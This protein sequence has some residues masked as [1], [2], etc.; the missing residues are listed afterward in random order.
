MRSY[1]LKA[2]GDEH[3]L[4]QVGCNIPS[5]KQAFERRHNGCQAVYISLHM[6]WGR[7]THYHVG[8]N[9]KASNRRGVVYV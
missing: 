2:P 7:H 8:H 3:T 1:F 5:S 6:G 9:Q 4:K